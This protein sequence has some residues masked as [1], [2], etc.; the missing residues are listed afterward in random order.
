MLP[1]TV[2]E[3]AA[4]AREFELSF[5][6]CGHL[7]FLSQVFLKDS[8]VGGKLSRLEILG[9]SRK[10]LMEM[11]N[12][13][14]RTLIH[15]RTHH[16]IEVLLYNI[17]AGKINTPTNFGETV[18]TLLRIWEARG[19]PTDAPDFRW[20]KKY[21]DIAENLRSGEKIELDTEPPKPFSMEEMK[22]VRKLIFE[23]RSIRQWSSKLIP[24]EMLKEIL[25]AGLM[26]PQGCNVGSTRF[27]IL[28]NPSSFGLVESDIRVENGVMILVC[29]DM[30]VYKTVRFD[31]RVPQN[32]YYD[33]ARA[34]AKKKGAVFQM[35]YLPKRIPVFALD[36]TLGAIYLQI[37][38]TNSF[39][40]FV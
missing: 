17:L 1:Q 29:Q 9:Y 5:A 13:M 25:Y 27:I 38:S 35:D 22:A 11:D 4:K 19:N 37:Q 28:R 7:I 21:L 36:C 34:Q 32:I 33:A 2:H 3:Y 14:L 30:R 40:F 18:K 23:R 20:V 31:E 6:S 15:E 10:Q 16:T 26:A 39:T 12:V 24:E 8:R